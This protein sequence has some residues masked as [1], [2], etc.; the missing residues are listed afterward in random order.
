MAGVVR[1]LEDLSG[2]GADL[3]IQC[4]GCGH[5][6][7][8]P[9]SHALEI[10]GRRRWSTDWWAAHRRFRCRKCGSKHITLDADFYGHAV[11]QQRR[12]A[13]LA[14]VEETLRPGLRPP[15]PGVALAYWNRATEAERKKLVDRARS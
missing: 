8:V 1:W 12:P 15:P 9:I 4:R 7:T 14:A 10:F 2:K 5:D 3:L 6:R 11:R 13:V